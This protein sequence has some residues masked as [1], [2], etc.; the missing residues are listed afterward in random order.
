MLIKM[1]GVAFCGLAV[2]F[3]AAAEETDSLEL[4]V[5]GVKGKQVLLDA[6]KICQ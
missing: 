4:D 3:T 6:V 1:I 5:A 2:S